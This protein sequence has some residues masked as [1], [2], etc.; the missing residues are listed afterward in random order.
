M[1]HQMEGP[2]NGPM[3]HLMESQREIHLMNVG[4]LSVE[5]AQIDFCEGP[6]I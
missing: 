4:Y 3:E 1:E 5:N 6:A 2:K